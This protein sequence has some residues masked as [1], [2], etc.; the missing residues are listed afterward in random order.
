MRCFAFLVL[1]M[2]GAMP[3]PALAQTLVQFPGTSWSISPPAG[4]ALSATPTAAIRHPGGAAIV[5]FEIPR[6]SVSASE[7]GVIGSVSGAGTPNEGRLEAAEQVMVAGRSAVLSTIRMTKNRAT[8]VHSIMV[9]GQASNVLVSMAV[10]DAAGID[11]AAIRSALLSVT[12]TARSIEL[13]LGDVPFRLPERAGMRIVNILANSVVILTEG[14]SDQF[15]E[16][17]G[18]PF[19]FVSMF[20]MPPGEHF[21]P[22]RDMSKVVARIKQEYPNATIVSTRVEQTPQGPVAAIGYQRIPPGNNIMVAGTAWMRLSGTYLLFMIAQ[23]PLTKPEMVPRMAKI[24]DGV[25]PK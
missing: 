19:A 24:R 18:Q 16:A 22:T 6:Q 17:N 23:Y 20:K 11:R 7:M 2:I 21:D 10:P 4:F 1:V 8:P 14:P 9:E 5:M 13:R 25:V 12:E 3:G 15:D